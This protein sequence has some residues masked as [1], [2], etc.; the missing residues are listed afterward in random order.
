MISFVI[1][2]HN[3][4]AFLGPTLDALTVAALKIGI[5]HE[6]I[7]VNDASTDGTAAVATQRGIRVIDVQHRHIAATRNSGGQAANG[8]I[9]VFLDADTR[10]DHLALQ[11]IVEAM[12]RGAVGGGFHFR[13]DCKLPW[14]ARILLPLGNTIGRWT[15]I[16]GGACLFAKRSVFR[17]MGGFCEKI[18]AAEDVE[19]VSSLKRHG[20]FVIPKPLVV[21]SAR[22]IRFLTSVTAMRLLFRLAIFGPR[23][24]TSREGLGCW[25]G[26]EA[27][28]SRRL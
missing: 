3:E 16:T 25:Y 13:Y 24:F 10:I 21:T 8:E 17:E 11:A 7:V 26:A 19:F 18:F 22:K 2:A 14:W 27:Q 28:Q 5:D 23:S 6:V 9:V 15:T 20:R 4:E 12:D 1:P